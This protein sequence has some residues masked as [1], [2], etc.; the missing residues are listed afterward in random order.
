MVLVH[1]ELHPSALLISDPELSDR[2]VDIKNR[3][4]VREH[5]SSLNISAVLLLVVIETPHDLSAVL[6]QAPNR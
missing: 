5:Y 1:G 6:V 4:V 3:D 2:Q